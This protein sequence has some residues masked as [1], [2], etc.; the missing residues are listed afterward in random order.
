[1][2]KQLDNTMSDK[3]MEEFFK[4]SNIS[5]EKKKTILHNLRA[6]IVCNDPSLQGLLTFV[7][8][9]VVPDEHPMFNSVAYTTGDVMFFGDKFFS[10]G[11]P[12]QC[13]IIYHEM[14][15]IVFRHVNR[16]RKRIHK[17]WNIAC[18]AII[19]DSIGYKENASMNVD[20][21]VYLEKEHC[22]SLDSLYEE[23][24]ISYD[25]R[26]SV[27]E[28]TS[29]ELYEFLIKKLKDDLE[30]KVKQQQQ[31]GGNGKDKKDGKDGDGQSPGQSSSSSKNN[32]NKSN[33][34]NS[35][36]P[37]GDLEQEIEDLLDRLAKKHKMF[38]GEDMKQESSESE[39]P[40]NEQVNDSKWTQ[41]Y[42]RAKSQGIG[43]NSIL[44]RINADVY[45]PQIPWYKELRKYLV[46]R[47]MPLFE[48]SWQRPAR[49]L[50]SLRSR[51]SRTYLPGL[52]KQKGLDKMLVIIDTSGSCFNEEELS[53]FCSEIE[54]V[55]NQTGVEVALIFADTCVRSEQIVK[56]D[57][58]GLLDK[59]KTGKVRPQGGGGT[60]MVAPFLYGKKKYKPVLTVIASD[61]YT[62][63]PT[64]QQVKGTTLLWIIN[65]QVEIPKGAGKGLYIHPKR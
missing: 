31:E 28:W 29:E 23:V 63:F 54:S 55:Q 50:G 12:I 62:P 60:D 39:D 49:R 9:K 17:L 64:A 15:H 38:S 22:V 59:I 16:G 26:K 41:R 21:P 3:N 5:F 46:T 19:N 20:Q 42:N 6:R 14:F 1:M 32:S 58:T 52:Q 34:S 57:G 24:N 44:G 45:Q 35:S 27:N 43:S 4:P 33:S 40:V 18:D 47:C 37:L 61:G 8:H 7:P 25:D 30:E 36:N 13:A 65:T 2:V 56:A 53:M 48:N 51:G 10:V 11:I